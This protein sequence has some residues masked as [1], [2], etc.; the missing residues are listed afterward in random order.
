[1]LFLSWKQLGLG[2][3]FLDFE[4]MIKERIDGDFALLR[5]YVVVY[6]LAFRH[7]VPGLLARQRPE[8]ILEDDLRV[9][10]VARDSKYS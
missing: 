8:P 3:F 10:I 1:M 4:D 5:G 2:F 7:V 6:E 9:K